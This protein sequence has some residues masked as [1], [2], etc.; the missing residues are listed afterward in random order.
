MAEIAARYNA[1]YEAAASAHQLT[2]MQAKLLMLV[3]GEPLP[4][5]RLAEIFACDPANV[6]GIVDRLE[7]R[8]LVSRE[9]SPDDRRVKLIAVTETG[10]KVVGDLRGTLGFAAQPLRA[11][12]EPERTQLRDLLRKMIDIKTI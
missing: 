9:P 2:A 6:T 7:R 12:T 1:G 3:S 4:M 10:R 5:R 8:E 11:L